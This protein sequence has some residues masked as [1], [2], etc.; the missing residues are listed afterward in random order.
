MKQPDREAGSWAA[1]V[2][3]WRLWSADAVS[4]AR[5]SSEMKS[6]NSNILLESSQNSNEGVARLDYRK[7]L[8][9]NTFRIFTHFQRSK[10]VSG[11]MK[12]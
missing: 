2:R 6:E 4:W 12:D 5:I 3:A 8:A 9:P 10:G 1:C 7:T 11:N